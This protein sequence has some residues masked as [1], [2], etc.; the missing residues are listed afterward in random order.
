MAIGILRQLRTAYCR[1]LFPQHVQCT[2]IR[3]QALKIKT[4]LNESFATG[5]LETLYDK[6]DKRILTPDALQL[7]I[8]KALQRVY[9]DISVYKPSGSNLI[10]KIFSGKSSAPKGLYIH[11]AVGAGKTMLM[12]LFFDCCKFSRKRRVHFNAFMVDVHQKIHETK[13]Q[14]TPI[15]DSRK[16]K[17]FDPIPP[18]AARITK[19]S[20][21]ICFDEFQVT[22]IADAM[23]LKRLFT[24][25]FEN[26][27]IVVATSNRAP[28]DLYKNGL[29]RSNF[30]PFIQVLKDYCT[31]INLDSGVDYR[32]KG[33]IGQNT[34]FIKSESDADRQLDTIFKYLCSKEN[35]TVRSK[36]MTILGRNVT[37]QKSCGGV[38]DTNFKELCVRPLGANDYIHLT[39]YFHTI[40]IR[41]I[42]QLSLKYKSEARR[43]ITLIDSL[44]NYKTRLLLSVDV[45]L[46]KLFS[47]ERTSS[48]DDETRML[49]DDLSI[50]KHETNASA[51]IFTGDEEVFAFDRTLS[52][53][54]EMRTQEY[55]DKVGRK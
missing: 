15:K 18:V 31:I 51:S 45:P 46:S 5:P 37:F 43:F 28:D 53:L 7:R 25:L 4:Q 27:V 10:S 38:L 48:N 26:G 14:V 3:S 6:I 34:F 22:D 36:T 11:G 35:D 33:A 24:Q 1:R 55:W 19:E 50:N 21:L 23:I 30:V 29:Q 17:P 54:T 16:S 9:D 8:C 40:I 20:W 47:S 12:D 52:R 44:Y 49:M 42:P 41:D 39:Q 32:Q 13:S 2:W